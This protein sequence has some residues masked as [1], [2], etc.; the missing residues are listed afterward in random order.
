MVF[1]PYVFELLVINYEC[2]QKFPQKTFR[3]FAKPS[4]RLFQQIS[5]QELSVEEMNYGKPK[6]DVVL[7]KSMSNLKVVCFVCDSNRDRD[8]LCSL[9]IYCTAYKLQG[10]QLQ[11]SYNLLVMNLSITHGYYE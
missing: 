7:F 2:Y 11:S 6:Q 1:L 4:R 9:N 3:V 10:V 5:R 8:M